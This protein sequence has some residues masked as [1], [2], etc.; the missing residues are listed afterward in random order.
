MK[1]FLRNVHALLEQGEDLVLATIVASSGSTPRS[2]GAKMAVR[3]PGLPGER[4]V[5]TVGGGLTEAMAIRDAEAL[6]DAAPGTALLRELNLNRDLAAG[7]DMICG[8]QFTLLLEYLAPGC[9]GALA[10]ARM[11]TELRKGRACLLLFRLEE[12]K[13]SR[14][15]EHAVL[16]LWSAE[17]A[18][19]ASGLT[20]SPEETAQL[21]LAAQTRQVSG[22]FETSLGRVVVEPALPPAPVYLYGAGHVSRCTAHIAS[23]AGFRTV[24][25]DDRADFANTERFPDADR[26]VVLDSFENAMPEADAQ[27]PLEV[28]DQ[29]AFLVI[30]TRGHL[31][32]KTV[33][34]QAL[35]TSARYIGMIGSRKKR[36]D[37][38]AA[39]RKEGFTDAD[40]AR[41]HCPI[42]LS[43]GAQTPEEI[44]LSIVT[45][46]VAARAESAPKPVKER[47]AS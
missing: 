37:I 7:T 20:L 6:F 32:D 19:T 41:C 11:D 42:G 16:P 9:P 38:Y 40:I 47:P 33:L 28:P 27:G 45:E 46:L 18:T 10:L 25:L 36:D 15:T 43:I 5:G 14:A 23:F 26:I 35:R 34:A 4:I 21:R 30:L 3:R 2:S 8:G 44:A 17:T 39:L 1:R 24:V 31:H 22:L 29:D 13:P 12:G